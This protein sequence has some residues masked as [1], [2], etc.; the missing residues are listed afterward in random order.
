MLDQDRGQ[1][2]KEKGV[3]NMDTVRSAAD[4]GSSV[5]KR[6]IIEG[7][8]KLQSIKL[9]ETITIQSFREEG[10]PPAETIG[11]PSPRMESK[12]QTEQ[13][14]N[15]QQKEEKIPRIL[16][17]RRFTKCERMVATKVPHMNNPQYVVRNKSGL[18]RLEQP[19]D[20]IGTCSNKVGISGTINK[21]FIDAKGRKI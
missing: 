14:S 21:V 12:I 9:Q 6:E 20:P 16:D 3:I 17:H 19:L 7:D 18:A 8:S 10:P 11:Q 13:K 5:Y 1:G 2:S 15:Q 4:P